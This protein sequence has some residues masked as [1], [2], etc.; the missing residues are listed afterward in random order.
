MKDEQRKRIKSLQD[1]LTVQ[2]VLLPLRIA[3][4]E[5]GELEQERLEKSLKAIEAVCDKLFALLTPTLLTEQN[6]YCVH[7]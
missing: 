7:L 2:V 3:Q 4:A 6:N 1:T 5:A